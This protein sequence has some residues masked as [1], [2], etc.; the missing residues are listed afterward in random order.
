VVCAASDVAGRGVAL[1]GLV[2]E[3][4]VP[5]GDQFVARAGP[6][7]KLPEAVV[8]CRSDDDTEGYG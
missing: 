1:A 6:K 5:S 2:G 4:W 3:E 7:P 8:A